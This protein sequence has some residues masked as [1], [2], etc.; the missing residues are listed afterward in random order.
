MST[1]RRAA[2]ISSSSQWLMFIITFVK[3]VVVSRLL[4]P[5][6]IGTFTLAASLIFLAN[7][8]RIFGTWDYIVAQKTVTEDALRHCF[9]IVM[10]AGFAIMALFLSLSGP[11][12]RIFDSPDI[13]LLL[14][15][16]V[17]SFIVLPVGSVTMA[18]MQRNMQHKELSIIRLTGSFTDTFVTIALAL[19]GVGVASLG[20]GYFLSNIVMML[21][22]LRIAD[23][24][25]LYW[26]LFRGI[27][28]VLRFGVPAAMG[29]FLSQVGTAG[30]PLVLGLGSNPAIVGLFGRGQTLI[31]FLRQGIEVATRP[32]TQAWFAQKNRSEPELIANGYLRITAMLSGI[33]W[34]VYIGVFFSAPTLVPLFFGNQWAESIPVAQIL[35]FGGLVSFYQASG[36]SLLE[37]LG[38]MG[39][40][41]WYN[42]YAQGLRFLLLVLALVFGGMLLFAAALALSHLVSFI[43]ITA[44]LK[45]HTGLRFRHVAKVQ[46]PSAIV[47]AAMVAVSLIMFGLVFEDAA[48]NLLELLLYVL[49]MAVTWIGGLKVIG[50][51]LWLEVQGILARRS[52]RARAV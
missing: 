29:T 33:A 4:D 6:E 52:E 39:Q 16:M 40:R 19:W 50:H 18:M 11:L 8:L 20:W 15:I 22:L 36:I 45:A 48:L 2:I 26:P 1:L 10:V 31:T 32:V 17:P 42:I 21:V 12:A 47:A 23:G 25:L 5:T 44:F 43:L 27:G 46:I 34:P 3:M 7:F 38:E 30:P 35:A 24:G 41:L 14:W 28:K 13:T 9:T 37:G 49:A 51:P